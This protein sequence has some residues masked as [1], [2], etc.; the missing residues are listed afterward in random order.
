M[1]QCIYFLLFF[2]CGLAYAQ[3]YQCVN[4]EGDTIFTDQKCANGKAVT[5]KTGQAINVIPFTERVKLEENN[6]MKVIY[7]G[8][9]A[10]STSRFLRVSIHE[11][12]DSYMIFF[13]E[14]YYNG[15]SNGR[16]EFR[17]TPNIHWSARSFSTSE[18]GRSSGYARVALGSKENDKA[19]SD[20]IT[21]QLWYYSPQNKAS[22]VETKVIPYKKTWTKKDK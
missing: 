18:K 3:V 8:K 15:P 4:S 7:R 20:I 14:G 5:P 13:V 10:G 9:T 16:A 1:K 21:L 2:Q 11:E 12:T 19:V 6:S 17:V 22:V